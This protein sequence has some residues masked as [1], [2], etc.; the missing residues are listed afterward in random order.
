MDISGDYLFDAPQN[1]VWEA[2]LDPNVLG[3][4]M[5]GGQGIEEVGENAYKGMLQIKIGP[6]QG[7]FQGDIQLTDIKAPESYHINVDGKGA[8]GFVKATGQLQLEGR[9]N[10]QT[11]MTYSGQAQIGGRIASVGQRLIDSS[12][13]SIIRQSLE[14]LNEYLKVKVAEQA[15]SLVPAYVSAPTSSEPVATPIAAQPTPIVSNYKP[16]SQMSLM[17]NVMRDVISDFIP[18]QYQAPIL[19]ATLIIIVVLLIWFFASR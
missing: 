12:A 10:N 1:M 9:D 18:M 19:V 3:S 5:P 17:L 2:L 6:V 11:F 14:A 15:A 4:I 16:P 7:T 13:R 8:P